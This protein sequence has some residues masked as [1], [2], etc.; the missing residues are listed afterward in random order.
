MGCVTPLG[1][2]GCVLFMVSVTQG[3]G[4]LHPASPLRI[5]IA[6]A[7][8]GGAL[9]QMEKIYQYVIFW[10]SY[11]GEVLLTLLEIFKT[12]TIKFYKFL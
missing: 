5:P 6:T 2:T 7:L 3:G 11:K 8:K 12:E 1:A 4:H 10:N 9:H